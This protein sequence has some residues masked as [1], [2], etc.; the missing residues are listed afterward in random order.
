MFN[1][2][3]IYSIIFISLS[4]WVVYAYLTTTEIIQSQEKYAHIINISG[5]QRMLSQKTTLIAKRYYETND[6]ELK[7]HLIEL[8]RLMKKDH[9]EIVNTHL[10][11][12]EI[13]AVYQQPPDNLNK[14]VENYLDMLASFIENKD[15]QMLKQIEK[16]SFELLP[17]INKTVYM[18]ENESNEKT[19]ALM[20]REFFILIGTLLT[21][22]IEAIV[23]VI[24]AIRIASRKDSEL[25]R[26]IEERTRELE[27]LSVT[28][29]LTK[30]YN[31]RKIDDILATEVEQARRYKNSF[32]LILIDID[33]FKK[34]NDRY[35]H[36][37]G[38]RVLQALSRLFSSSI[39]KTDMVGRWGGEEFLIISMENDPQKV[40]IFVEKLRALVDEHHFKTVGNI[41]CSFGV[42]HFSKGDSIDSLL[43]RADV[44]LYEA[45]K[46]GRNCVK[47]EK[48]KHL[49]SV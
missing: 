17:Q 2:K 45:K 21:L 8:Y 23:I 29:Q 16:A 44:A 6:P 4:A 40:L 47:I 1:L 35:G 10:L 11:S 31:R 22:I 38:D 3:V 46:A 49:F 26:L 25:L 41:T 14:K 37:V 43:Q 48:T 27:K 30:L 24:P 13:K 5:K 33:H 28:D 12:E 42:S 19:Q 34:I 18:F 20:D 36:L 9:Q 7:K 15:P 32:S 39:R